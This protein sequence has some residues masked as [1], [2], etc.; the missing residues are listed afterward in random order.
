MHSKPVLLDHVGSILPR[1]IVHWPQ[2][3]G[4]FYSKLDQELL[5][6]E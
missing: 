3:L 1:T 4:I 5:K 6:F 2:D